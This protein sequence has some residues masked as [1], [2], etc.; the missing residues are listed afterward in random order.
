MICHTAA[1]KQPSVVKTGGITGED[2]LTRGKKSLPEDADLS[3][4]GM[5]GK[6]KIDILLL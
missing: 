3:A 4:V 2:P 5:A 1:D 6:D